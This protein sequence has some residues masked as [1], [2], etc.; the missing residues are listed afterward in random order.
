MLH[1]LYPLEE[2]FTMRATKRTIPAL[3][4]QILDKFSHICGQGQS[5]LGQGWTNLIALLD[6]GICYLDKGGQI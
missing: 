2:I 4:W 5:F 3:R 6:K 1:Y